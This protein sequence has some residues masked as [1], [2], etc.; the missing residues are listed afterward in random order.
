MTKGRSV[1]RRRLVAATALSLVGAIPATASAQSAPP[2]A[3]ACPPGSWFCAEPP[4][5]QAV[6]AGR[7]V[8]SLEPLPDPDAPPPPPPRP[9][10][11]VTYSP[12]PPGPPPPLPPPPPPGSPPT[13]IYRPPPPALLDSSG[14]ATPGGGLGG[15]PLWFTLAVVA[16]T[17]LTVEW[18]L[19]QRRWIS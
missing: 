13:V 7:P 8:Q 9:R 15:W 2:P 12:Y 19:Y 1:K 3:S 17:L 11:A 18:Y 4:Q 16:G 10:P 6:P 5:E 14:S